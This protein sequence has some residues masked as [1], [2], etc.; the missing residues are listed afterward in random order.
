[1]P[2]ERLYDVFLTSTRWMDCLSVFF[3]P[4][5]ILHSSPDQNTKKY[6]SLNIKT[7]ECGTHTWPIAVIVNIITI[8]LTFFPKYLSISNKIHNKLWCYDF[9]VVVATVTATVMPLCV[10]ICVNF[11][12]P[13][14]F[15][16]VFAVCAGFRSRCH[17][18]W[19]WFIWLTISI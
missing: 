9:Y 1:M 5:G 14:F 18:Y 10:C 12:F 6:A 8:I 4:S 15:V 7:L 3:L 2:R 17:F 16:C 19:S 13:F 11:H